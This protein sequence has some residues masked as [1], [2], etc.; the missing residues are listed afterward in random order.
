MRTALDITFDVASQLVYLDLDAR[1]TSVTSVT[2]HAW[3]ESDDGTEHSTAVGAGSVE[4][5]PD[6]TV[7]AASGWGQADARVIN[8]AATT[9]FAIGRSYL[10]ASANGYSETFEVLEIAD[11]VSV[12]ARHP[13]HN[14][15]ASGDTVESTRITATID[16]TWV[17][18]EANLRGDAGPNPAYRVRWV[19]V[20]DG[21]THVGE[22]AFNLVRYIGAHGVR[23][24]DVEA[25]A[26]GWLNR[27]P[28]DHR[29]D[30]GRRLINEAYRGVKLD[31]HAIATDDAMIAEPE[32]IDELTR[33]KA[34]ELATYS[35]ALVNGDTSRYA[36]AQAA[37][38][39]RFDSLV[40]ITKKV[41]ERDS[42][43]A[44]QPGRTLG[45]TRR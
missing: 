24:D 23:P 13:L 44:A 38:Q 7:D 2:V 33:Y 28:T 32:V 1:P 27:L 8:V 22:S 18:D 5:D 39:R 16:S 30:Q 34:V 15:Y 40:R 11:G 3:D 42:T 26:P 21:E 6:T 17:A 31:L 10:L 4:P 37:Y 43:G 12:T 19:Y 41:P 25:M 20:I 29:E 45:L 36:L 9:G 14:T 35:N